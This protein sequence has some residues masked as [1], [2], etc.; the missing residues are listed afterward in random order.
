M[1]KLSKLLIEALSRL[2]KISLG[3]STDSNTDGDENFDEHPDWSPGKIVVGY[4]DGNL[5]IIGSSKHPGHAEL[6]NAGLTKRINYAGRI[7][8]RYNILHKTL[9]MWQTTSTS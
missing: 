7:A 4:V 2:K 1:I 8:W 9:F 5:N 6:Y 3:E